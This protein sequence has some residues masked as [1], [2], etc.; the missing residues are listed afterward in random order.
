MESE[1][2]PDVQVMVDELLYHLE[3]EHIIES[4]IFCMRSYGA[5]VNAYARI[6]SLPS[7]WRNALEINPFYLIEVVSENFDKLS[8]EKKEKVILH[9]LLHIP[10]RFSGGLVAH[11]NPG[12]R[13]DDK[14]V[15]R[16]YEEYVKKKNNRPL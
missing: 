11:N 10:K 16:I 15:N 3:F 6:W 7:I 8:E 13:I 14:K 12:E 5:K 2:A 9:E 4:R 1:K